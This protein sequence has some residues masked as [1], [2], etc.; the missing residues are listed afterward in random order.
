MVEFGLEFDVEML[1]LFGVGVK[2]WFYGGTEFIVVEFILD[3]PVIF[4]VLDYEF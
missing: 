4:M 2:F 1:V 3:A